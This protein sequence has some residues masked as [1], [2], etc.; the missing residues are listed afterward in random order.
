MLADEKLSVE[1]DKWYDIKVAI[2]GARIRC[3]LDGELIHDVTGI[4]PDVTV[5]ST[6]DETAGEIILKIVNPLPRP[7]SAQVELHGIDTVQPEAHRIL[8]A[9]DA[10]ARNTFEQPDN[11]APATDR[12]LGC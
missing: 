9:A 7:L 12:I 11:V 1:T 3:F 8:L 10:K 2:N 4:E 5:S 6:L